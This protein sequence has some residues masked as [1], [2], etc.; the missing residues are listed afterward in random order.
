MVP[1]PPA[2]GTAAL[3][4][5]RRRQG[6]IPG[7]I[8]PLDVFCLSEA[9][10]AQSRSGVRGDILEIGAFKGKSA[11][12][13][14]IVLASGEQLS[15]CDLFGPAPANSENAA[16]VSQHYRSLDRRDFEQSYRLFHSE[17]PTIYQC[18]SDQLSALLDPLARFRLVHVDG[19]HLYDAVMGDATTARRHLLPGGIV[20]FDDYRA[21]HAPG[22][23]AAVWEQVATTGLIPLW[24]TDSKFYGSWQPPEEGLVGAIRKRAQACGISTEL[25]ELKHH[26]FLRLVAP[27]RSIGQRLQRGL[28]P[29]AVGWAV[30]KARAARQRRRLASSPG[31]N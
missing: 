11:A 23:A 13:L 7:N 30:S 21:A 5:Y 31:K 20:V 14:G 17:L 29:P 18:S 24:L 3:A 25:V 16:E 9:A 15:V 26:R 4:D 2:E 12:L 27:P 1:P 19:S 22:V 6:G 10:W 28:V 8:D